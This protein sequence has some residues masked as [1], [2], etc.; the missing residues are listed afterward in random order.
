MYPE[1][2]QKLIKEFSRLPGVGPKAAA[3]FVFHL[4]RQSED[5]T[6]SLAASLADL[7]K[8][9]I[10]C[11]FC[12][13][14]FEPKSEEMLC[15]ICS[16]ARRDQTKICVVE[17]EAD[18]ELLEK[19][20]KYRGLYFVLGSLL[21]PLQ[22]KETEKLIVHDFFQRLKSPGQFGLAQASF[23]EI[24]LA[25]SYTTEGEATSLYLERLLAPLKMTADS[26]IKITRLGRG[27][28]LGAEIEYADEE[29]ISFALDNRKEI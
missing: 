4:L 12:R 15:D 17:K 11:S 14:P 29:T 28:P 24:I 7:K 27:L 18:L 21:T 16:D 23:Q 26:K 22:K 8:K 2:I 9:V 20:H 10:L 13:N 19:T 3:R 1:T 6:N 25:V 5:E